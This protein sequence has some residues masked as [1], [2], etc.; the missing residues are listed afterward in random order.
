MSEGAT[1]S[2]RRLSPTPQRLTPLHLPQHTALQVQQCRHGLSLANIKT[3]V[4]P[5]HP[6]ITRVHVE[7]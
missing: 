7:G 2:G 1:G 3:L 6:M 5:L 4:T